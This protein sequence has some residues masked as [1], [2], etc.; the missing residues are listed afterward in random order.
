MYIYCAITK[1]KQKIFSKRILQKGVLLKKVHVHVITTGQVSYYTEMQYTTGGTPQGKV[2]LTFTQ[3]LF[4]IVIKTLQLIKR[5]QSHIMYT[6][7]YSHT[8]IP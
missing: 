7:T 1:N 8:H 2:K 6:V 4:S 5:P 3:R